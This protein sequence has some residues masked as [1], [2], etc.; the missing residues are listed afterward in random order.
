M[1]S[2]GGKNFALFKGSM[3]LFSLVYV[4]SAKEIFS[5]DEL[6]ALLQTSRRNNARVGITGMLLYKGG[7][8][9]QALEGEQAAIAQLHDRIQSDRRHHGLLTL[10]E[11]PIKERQFTQWSMGFSNLGDPLLR[12]LPGYSDFLDLPLSAEALSADPSR[13]QKLLQLFRTRM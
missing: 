2:A 13:A 7:N 12:G 10:L 3:S 11:K 8:F 9:I 5:P 4:S 6:F 1:R